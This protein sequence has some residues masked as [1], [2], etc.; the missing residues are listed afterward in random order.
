MTEAQD[1]T[2]LTV[3][4]V[5]ES[6]DRKGLLSHGISRSVPSARA[7]GRAHTV[8]C[9]QDDNLG[10]HIAIDELRPGEILVATMP[11]PRPVALVGEVLAHFAKV[12][13][14][15]GLLIDAAVRDL[16]ELALV[17]LPI[18]SRWVTSS[19]SDKTDPGSHNVPVSVAEQLINPGDLLL[20]DGD[21]I[22][23]I[24]PEDER[25]A[26]VEARRRVTKEEEILRELTGGKSTLDLMNLRPLTTSSDRPDD[27]RS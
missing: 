26:L 9:A 18:W 11:E 4:T 20:L 19:G 27:T 8:L 12:K 14:A 22:L 10:V 13:G 24:R 3:S 23:H 5:Y 21:G 16:D 25:E 15:A 1:W 17:G 6:V 2:G 7:V